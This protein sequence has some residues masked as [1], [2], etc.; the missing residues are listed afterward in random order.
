MY[1]RQVFIA[2]GIG[3]TP[4]RSIVKYATEEKLPHKIVLIYSNLTPETS[5][6]LNELQELEKENKN[7]TL[8]ATMTEAKSSRRTWSGLTGYIDANFLKTNIRELPGTIFY[9]V[10][11]PGMVEAAAKALEEIGVSHDDI[12]FE[13]FTG[14]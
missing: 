10:G 1:K 11:P 2:G 9:L 3:I 13:E 4:V 14:Y 5:P 12:R 7:F 8:L 6:F